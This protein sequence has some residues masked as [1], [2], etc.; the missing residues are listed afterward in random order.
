MTANEHSLSASMW[1]ARKIAG[2][3]RSDG[4]LLSNI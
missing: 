3:V 2:V 4:V 1:A